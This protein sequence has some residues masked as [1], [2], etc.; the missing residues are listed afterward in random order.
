MGA[1]DS[2]ARTFA[3][4]FRSFLEWVHSDQAGARGRNEV[5]ALVGDFLGEEAVER[6]VVTR[7]LSVSEHVNLQTALDAWS[8]EPGR[9]VVVQGISIPPHHGSVTLQ[10]LVT[11]E[12]PAA[13]APDGAGAR[14][15]A[16]RAGLDAG[17]PATSRAHW[18]A[19]RTAD[20]W[21]W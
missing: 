13:A 9:E 2:E 3:A 19:T 21:C 1:S 5:A 14:G 20:T 8:Q 4:A 6:S 17:L 10:Q 12:S 11:G 15:P 18:S 16:Q 7:S